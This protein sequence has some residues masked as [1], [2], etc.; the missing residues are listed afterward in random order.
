VLGAGLATFPQHATE[1]KRIDRP[2]GSSSSADGYSST[3][4]VAF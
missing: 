2:L 1:A 4:R 3:S